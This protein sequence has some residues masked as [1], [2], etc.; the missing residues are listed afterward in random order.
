MSVFKDII[1]ADVVE[2]LLTAHLKKWLPDYL[3]EVAAQRGL[4]RGD[5]PMPVSWNITPTFDT[6]G[7]IRVPAMLIVSGGF[8]ESPRKQGDGG[9][10]AT[11]TMG[12]AALVSAKDQQSTRRL[13]RRYGAVI[14]AA[15][16]QQPS[17]GDPR[18]EGV[19]WVD[20]SF[21]DIPS[22]Q[23]T[24]ASANELFNVSM[25]GVLNAKAGPAQP[26]PQP[27]PM[28]QYPDR[29]TVQQ[30]SVSVT[31]EETP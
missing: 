13:A 6:S 14:S 2:D 11:W 9:Y 12:V 29:P 18:I 28:T 7:V 17:L 15:I 16:M 22:D 25:K 10:I 4:A 31:N 27:D 24:L 23:S 5:I 30:I 3:A 21:T 19:T 26:E 8:A 1:S 20:E